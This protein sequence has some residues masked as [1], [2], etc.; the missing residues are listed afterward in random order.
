M[1]LRCSK[2]RHKGKTYTYWKLV[3]YVRQCGRVRQEVV[4]HLGKIDAHERR[5]ASSLAR[6][7]LGERVEQLSLFEDDR[8]LPVERV[9]LGDVRVERSRGF[10]DVWLGWLLW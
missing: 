6:H 3:R 2:K 1:Y 8:E 9:R 4:A 10:G 7:F 5:K